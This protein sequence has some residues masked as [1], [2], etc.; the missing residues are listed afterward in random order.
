MEKVIPGMDKLLTQVVAGDA[1]ALARLSL[2]ALGGEE[3]ARAAIEAIDK[4]GWKPKGMRFGG[5]W[6][7]K[8]ESGER[9]PQAGDVMIGE[10]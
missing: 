4:K 10:V 7:S 5:V 1:N 2:I 6:P 3:G 9:D 8:V